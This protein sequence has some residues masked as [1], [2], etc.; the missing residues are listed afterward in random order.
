MKRIGFAV[1][2]LL[3]LALPS[4][5]AGWVED[6]VLIT[7]ASNDQDFPQIA[8]TGD[9][10]A[11]IVWEDD[12]NYLTQGKNLYAQRVDT[13][14]T[15]YWVFNGMPVCRADGPQHTPRICPDGAGGA[16]VCWEDRLAGS[17]VYAQRIDHD[18]G[19]LWTADGLAVCDEASDQ[20]YPLLCSDGE[21]GALVAWMDLRVGDSDIFA[22]LVTGSGDLVATMLQ[23]S[24]A[25]IEEGRVALSW[26]LSEMDAGARFIVSR[27]S[28]PGWQYEPVADQ[29]ITGDGLS[30]TFLDESVEPCGEYRYIVEAETDDAR[31]LLFETEILAIPA[32]ALA[33]Y[34]N[35]PNPFN[36]STTIRYYLP[37]NAPVTLEIFGVSGRLVR[38]LID[39]E[40]QETGPSSVIW[41]GYDGN[42]DRVESGLYFYRLTV[43][44]NSISRK[45]LLLR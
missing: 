36:P 37:E 33:L 8:S 15:I 5:F 30:F 6:G 38:R 27:S 35:H 3:V 40:R 39:G 32:A 1:I 18:G 25:G 9:G 42:G 13:A 44:K 21:N 10:G 34:Q 31:I 24:R 20:Y 26:T 45:M 29:V 43:G 23:S 7:Y 16:V 41:N 12:R 28:A 14:G 22:S 11:I 4:L 2:L 17:D 19:A